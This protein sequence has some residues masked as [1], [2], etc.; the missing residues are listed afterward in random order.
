MLWAFSPHLR[1]AAPFPI[2]QGNPLVP[3]CGR[4]GAWAGGGFRPTAGGK[5]A[6]H[7]APEDRWIC[8]DWGVLGELSASGDLLGL[9]GPEGATEV[10]ENI[11]LLWRCHQK[12]CPFCLA[13]CR[14]SLPG[15]R[16]RGCRARGSELCQ[17][18]A[19]VV[20]SWL[21][22]PPL[23]PPSPVPPGRVPAL[24]LPYTVHSVPK[25]H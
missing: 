3:L 12:S 22:P 14:P 21:G 20:K 7:C 18:A 6:P 19:W 8:G 2:C 9:L 4:S 11:S 13:F 23:P 15:A 24:H 16:W 17:G 10:K 25:Q 5:Q 1:A